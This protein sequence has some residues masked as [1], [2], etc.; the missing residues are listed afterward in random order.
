MNNTNSDQ[1]QDIV[2][3]ILADHKPLKELI[4]VMKD[5]DQ[6][7]E[8]R[9]RSLL[10]FAPLLLAHAKPEER[11]LYAFMKTSRAFRIDG[12]E[13]EAEH[14]LADQMVD[15]AKRATERDR[16]S[17]KIKMLAE[18]VERHIAEEENEILPHFKRVIDSRD[19]MLLADRY[20]DIK[21]QIIAD[22]QSPAPP[23]R[24]RSSQDYDRATFHPHH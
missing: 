17:S 12:V 13:G 2:A 10:E 11:S 21:A 7:L 3:I 4:R 5:T 23:D 1:V 14:D 6:P 20:L 8:T 15:E 9:K 19:L 18:F 24:E 22:E 16:Q